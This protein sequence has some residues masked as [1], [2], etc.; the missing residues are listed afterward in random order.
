MDRVITRALL[1]KVFSIVAQWAW[2]LLSGHHY[3]HCCGRRGTNGQISLLLL[4]LL[5]KV[6][7]LLLLRQMLLL[8]LLMMLPIVVAVCSSCIGI[9]ACFAFAARAHHIRQ[10]ILC[11]IAACDSSCGSGGVGVGGTV[12]IALGMLMIA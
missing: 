8:L 3:H 1:S 2:R 4:L 12:R 6:L 7:L 10:T 9:L 5:L 11:P